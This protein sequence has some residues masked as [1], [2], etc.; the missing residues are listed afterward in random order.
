[1][2][3]SIVLI[4]SLEISNFKNKPVTAIYCSTIVLSMMIE[5]NV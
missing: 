2:V 5:L 4:I 3:V 1:M